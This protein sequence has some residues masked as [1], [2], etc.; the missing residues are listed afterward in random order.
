MAK[1]FLVDSSDGTRVPFLRGILTRSLHEAGLGFAEAY[2]LATQIRQSLSESDEISIDELRS[3]VFELLRKSHSDEIAEAYQSATSKVPATIMV[4]D[5]DGQSVPFSQ[6]QLMR[7]FESCGLKPKQAE[8]ASIEI[9][10]YLLDR[11]YSEITSSELG[12]HSYLSLQRRF[13]PEMARRYLV[14]MDHLHSGRPI[15]LLIGG[16]TG[17]GKSTI[18]TEVA[19]RLGVVRTQSTD[20]LREVMRMLIPERLLPVLHKSSFNAWKALPDSDDM[21]ERDEALIAAGYRNQMELLSVPCEAVIQRA[22]KERVSLIL[23]GVHAHPSMIRRISGGEDAVIVPVIL[24]ILKKDKLRGRL[25]GR[26]RSVPERSAKHYLRNFE[27]IWSLQSF[28]LSEADRAGV[29]II[30]N[31]DVDNATL[32]VMASIIDKLSERFDSTPQEVFGIHEQA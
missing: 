30:P 17:C 15:I 3:R 4:R 2:A 9:Y 22:L 11:E 12:Y 26:G 6:G 31:D 5:E 13:G 8:E 28:L 16:T 20:M 7:C 27:R 14:W 23:E 29:S 21:R 10:Q 1:T 25:V 24:A 18:A 19:H 32:Q